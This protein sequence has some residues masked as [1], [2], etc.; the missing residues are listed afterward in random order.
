MQRS[1]RSGSTYFLV[2]DR[3]NESTSLWAD[4]TNLCESHPVIR[5]PVNSLT[6][7]SVS[8]F[9]LIR[10]GLVFISCEN[11]GGHCI[12]FSFS[13][14]QSRVRFP[15]LPKNFGTRFFWETLLR[16]WTVS[17]NQTNP[18][19]TTQASTNPLGAYAKLVL[20]K[21][22]CENQQFAWKWKKGATWNHLLGGLAPSLTCV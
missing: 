1:T 4:C 9:H 3:A 18:Y 11:H 2:V 16:Q 5:R 7:L 17:I 20:Q 21:I 10:L 19:G 13:T 22:S 15:A 12:A 14:Q 6:L 8:N